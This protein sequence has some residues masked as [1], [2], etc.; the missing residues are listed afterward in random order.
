MAFRADVG[1]IDEEK[2]I[3]EIIFSTGAP[4]MRYDWSSG[5]RYREVLSMD[6]A[7]VRMKR[8]NTV[9]SLLDS[10]SAWSVGDVLG[11]IEPDSGRIEKGKGYAQVRFSQRDAVT[12]IWGD[13]KDRI[14]RS[15]SVG[16][17]VYKYLE[18]T[19]KDGQVAT[20][21]AVDWEPFE[22]SLVPMPADIG[23]TLRAVDKA[24][25]HS[26]VIE[27]AENDADRIRR[28]RLAQRRA[29]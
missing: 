1:V 23:A 25:A 28:F 16:Y 9:G 11:A 6:P 5:R 4:V 8:L 17:N 18:E 19:G 29:S 14:L 21:T 10:H 3:V 22:V 7:H 12:P 27:T 15:F 2:R 26:C 20:R 24:R 13:V